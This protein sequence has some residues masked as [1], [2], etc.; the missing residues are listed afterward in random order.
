MRVS[1]RNWSKPPLVK[2]CACNLTGAKTGNSGRAE[3]RPG[4]QGGFGGRDHV[5]PPLTRARACP[6]P[7]PGPRRAWHIS[8]V[9][10]V[11]D[12]LGGVSD[13]IHSVSV[14]R[15]LLRSE[16]TPRQ[17]LDARTVTMALWALGRME[18]PGAARSGPCFDHFG[19]LFD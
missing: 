2:S 18:A 9:C 6:R 7:G 12:T 17:D 10:G 13:T 4:G 11:S 15:S 14:T 8:A 1:A 3:E 19:L 16:G 5:L